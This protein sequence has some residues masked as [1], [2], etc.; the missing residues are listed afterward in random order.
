M[1]VNEM[2]RQAELAYSS[3]PRV[4][5]ATEVKPG[6]IAG[7]PTE[8][9]YKSDT[10]AEIMTLSRKVIEQGAINL[11]A[12]LDHNSRLILSQLGKIYSNNGNWM[13]NGMPCAETVVPFVVHVSGSALAANDS[14]SSYTNRTARDPEGEVIEFTEQELDGIKSGNLGE[15]ARQ[16]PAA[17]ALRVFESLVN[18][19]NKTIDTKALATAWNAIYNAAHSSS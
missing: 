7:S 2:R 18:K 12:F 8:P 19:Q 3:R 4:G 13:E 11:P 9:A 10:D 1:D 15:K 17:A 14:L 5:A 16:Y 6:S